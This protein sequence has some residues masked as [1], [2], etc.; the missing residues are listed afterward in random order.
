MTA[1]RGGS[2][3]L[4]VVVLAVARCAAPSPAQALNPIKP[5]CSLAGLVS[6]L[7]GKVCSAASHPG[8]VLS[9]GKRLLGG[10]LGGAVESL[11][12]QGASGVAK[13]AAAA[14]GI[15][16]IGTW[17]AGGAKFALNETASV[18]SATTRPELQGTWFSSVYWRMAAISALLT[19]PFLFAAAIQAITH[20][21]LALLTRAALG[22]LPLAVLAVSVAAPVTTLL[23]AASDEMSGIVSSASN[24]ASVSFLAHA[25][26]V[27]GGVTVLSRSPFLVFVVG[28]LTAAATLTLWIELVIRSA[29]VYVIVLLLPLFFA[30]LVWP[31]RRIW[32][33]R[34]V[35]LLVA[36]ILSKFA[37]VAVLALGGAALGHTGSTSVTTML[38]GATLVL[39]AAFS[40]WALL[41]MLPLHELAGG[42]VGGLRS[43]TR[44]LPAQAQRGMNTSDVAQE[45]VQE[46]PAQLALREARE[47]GAAQ[48]ALDGLAPAGARSVNGGQDRDLDHGATNGASDA[49]HVDGAGPG[50]ARSTSSSGGAAADSLADAFTPP[51][52][53]STPP[54]SDSQASEAAPERSPGMSAYAQAP[55]NSLPTMTLGLDDGWPPRPLGSEPGPGPGPA[56]PGDGAAPG[57]ADGRAAA[58]DHDPRPP[59]QE[60]DEGRL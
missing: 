26:Q 43:E 9:A 50:S 5:I 1:R 4:L 3:L 12:G 52:S 40:P 42:A 60:P 38:A 35:E 48:A 46:L 31:A 53:G 18:I 11:A 41:R 27:A 56:A 29:A 34:A 23:L 44:Q 22:Y 6:T 17:V 16:A 47:T 2:I 58:E 19:L 8:R 59:R 32:A 54:G 55:D 45:I 37:I 51:P 33:V 21:D 25:A 13:G 7:A 28:L 14:A 10:H 24:G 49:P 39:L 15:A 36:L 30:A 20:S 57:E